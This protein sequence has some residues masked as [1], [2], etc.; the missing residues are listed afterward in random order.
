MR[1]AGGSRPV[2]LS[3][4]AGLL[5][6][7]LGFAHVAF[8]LCVLVLN[9]LLIVMPLPAVAGVVVGGVEVGIASRLS[10][11]V[12]PVKLW[13]FAAGVI[14]AVYSLGCLLFVLAVLN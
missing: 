10:A 8:Y 4:P 11:S 13:L 6:V 2:P 7:V 9:L 1:H 3:G 14:T 12:T 5:T